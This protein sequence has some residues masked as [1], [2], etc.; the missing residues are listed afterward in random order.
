MRLQDEIA[1]I[2]SGNVHHVGTWGEY[3]VITNADT[4][5]DEILALFRERLL[6]D[7]VIEAAQDAEMRSSGL[8]PTSI[9]NAASRWPD[10]ASAAALR[11]SRHTA[12][13][14]IAAALDTITG[15]PS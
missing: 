13:M 4:S 2:I 8:E 5:A 15:K 3:E 9:R 12:V 1:N 7:E 14:M 6:S 10:G 11:E